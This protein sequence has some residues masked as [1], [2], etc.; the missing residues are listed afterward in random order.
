[1]LKSKV[2]VFID[3]NKRSA[4]LAT[5]LLLHRSAQRDLLRAKDDL[6]IKI[7]ER[8]ANLILAHDRLRSEMQMRDARRRGVLGPSRQPRSQSGESEFLAT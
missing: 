5:E 4:D 1:V 3:L 8:T 2:A 7:R 6:E